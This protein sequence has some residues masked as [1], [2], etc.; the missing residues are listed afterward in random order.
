MLTRHKIFIAISLT[1]LVSAAIAF[2]P[3]PG[4]GRAGHGPADGSRLNALLQ[5]SETQQQQTAD[6][7]KQHHEK[8]R[9]Q[10]TVYQQEL[11]Q[12][13]AGILSAEQ[14]QTFQQHRKQMQE[15]RDQRKMHSGQFR[16]NATPPMAMSGPQR[17]CMK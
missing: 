15:R 2:G 4:Y 6:I 17:N 1:A 13:L 3:Y 11:D 14:L 16:N 9:Q 10:Q 8:M 7:F 12:Q 5:L